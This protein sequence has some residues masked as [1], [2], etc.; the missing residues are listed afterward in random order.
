MHQLDLIV[1]PMYSA[2]SS[3]LIESVNR[4]LIGGKKLLAVR[5]RRDARVTQ[6][7][8]TSRFGDMQVPAQLVAHSREILTLMTPDTDIVA[9]DESQFFDPEIVEVVYSIRRSARVVASGLNRDFRG[10]P[11]GPIPQLLA[12]ASTITLLSAICSVCGEDAEY[13]QRLTKG[14]PSSAFTED[15]LIEGQ[16]ANDLYEPRCRI[17]FQPPPDLDIW[18]R[19][20]YC[21]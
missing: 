18:L 16:Q 8:I 2:K 15:I 19:T 21:P 1:G 10:L 13:S 3:R 14:Q 7:L 20:R 6:P 9:I 12:M 5:P 11:F 4:G 17:H